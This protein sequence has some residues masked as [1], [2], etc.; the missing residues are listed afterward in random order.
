L[1]Q[2]GTRLGAASKARAGEY[3]ND[4]LAIPPHVPVPV[5]FKAWLIGQGWI[6][7]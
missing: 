2:K 3:A 5:R 7:R 6:E 4:Q 1:H